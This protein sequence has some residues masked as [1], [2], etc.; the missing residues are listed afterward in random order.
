MD[1]I[2]VGTWVKTERSEIEAEKVPALNKKFG[3]VLK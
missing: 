2:N 3:M 1:G